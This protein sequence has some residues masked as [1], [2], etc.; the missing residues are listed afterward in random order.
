S[1]IA[2]TRL[3]TV[4]EF[5]KILLRV[6]PDGSKVTVGDVAHVELGGQDYNIV[7]RYN[8][9]P[10]TGLAINLATG[11]NALDTAKLVKE[12]LAELEQFFPTGVEL[13]IPYDTTQIGRAS[14]RERGEIT[15][16]DV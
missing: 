12:R 14:C 7:A 4:E 1:I 5:E 9:Q 2:Q 11:A 16:V 6:N 8:R 10:A 13:V 15:R 3:E